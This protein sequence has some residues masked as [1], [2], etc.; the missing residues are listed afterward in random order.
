MKC[1]CSSISPRR[2]FQVS[3]SASFSCRDWI[4]FWKET[5]LR[6]VLEL[7]FCCLARWRIGSNALFCL[8]DLAQLPLSVH[9]SEAE[10]VHVVLIQARAVR[11]G[12]QCCETASEDWSA[13]T[14]KITRRCKL[15][16]P[17]ILGVLVHRPFNVRRDRRGALVEHTILWQVVEEASHSHLAM[18]KG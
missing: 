17:E 7:A 14:G 9:A 10:Q 4:S 1:S 15:T 13:A 5:E 12:D 2:F 3:T 8:A 6:R 11:D 18:H 16:D